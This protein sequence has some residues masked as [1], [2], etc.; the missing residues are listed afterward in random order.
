MVWVRF[1]SFWMYPLLSLALLAVAARWGGP[2]GRP[3]L[4][5]AVGLGLWTLLEYALHR[6]V[7]H[8]RPANRRLKRF[9]A[10]L[11]L[12]HH[13]DPRN[14]GAILVR[15]GY[16]LTVS[17]IMLAVLWLALGGFGSAVWVLT[18]AWIGFL[19]YETVHYR[20]HKSKRS[21][22]LLGLQRR[23]HFYHH[24][25]DDDRCF[26]VTSPVWDWVFGTYGRI[27]PRGVGE[28]AK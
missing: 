17:A 26:G 5:L 24:F 16:S 11:H 2:T 19:Y 12:R 7:F 3:L 25:V 9:L 1:A 4:L 27:G 20:I 13:G 10:G 22:G 8:W 18:G 6:F 14:E 21:G 15:P 28:E 23:A